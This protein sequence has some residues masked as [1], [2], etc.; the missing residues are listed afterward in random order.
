MERIDWESELDWMGKF[1]AP[2]YYTSQDAFVARHLGEHAKAWQLEQRSAFYLAELQRSATALWLG[3]A[4]ETPTGPGPGRQ[5]AQEAYRNLNLGRGG[6]RVVPMSIQDM[7][8]ANRRQYERTIRDANEEEV[9]RWREHLASLPP[10]SDEVLM[11][12]AWDETRPTPKL[13]PG[14]LVW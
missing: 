8:S 7:L 5:I 2:F 6:Y 1:R 3:L 14:V 10:D 11:N 12:K 4:D 9:R 13:Q